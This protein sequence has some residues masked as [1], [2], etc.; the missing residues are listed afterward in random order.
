MTQFDVSNK[1]IKTK[2]ISLNQSYDDVVY[3]IK[4]DVKVQKL[5]YGIFQ[6]V[7][8]SDTDKAH[9]LDQYDTALYCYQN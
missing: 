3:Q 8:L 4:N 2:L 7:A 6:S 1:K 9:Q 5:K